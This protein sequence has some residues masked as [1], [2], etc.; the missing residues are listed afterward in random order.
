MSEMKRKTP[1]VSKDRE[2]KMDDL[3]KRLCAPHNW[4]SESNEGHRGPND[5]P[6]EAADRIEALEAENLILRVALEEIVVEYYKDDN[7]RTLRW[8]VEHAF[9]TLQDKEATN[10]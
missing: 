7:G 8:A 4:F 5:A 6:K 10:D 2:T 3:V 9:T 1:F